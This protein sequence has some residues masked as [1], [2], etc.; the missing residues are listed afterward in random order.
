M[1]S[2]GQVLQRATAVLCFDDGHGRQQWSFHDTLKSIGE[3]FK[4]RQ[5]HSKKWL[6]LR[7]STDY[8]KGAKVCIQTALRS[9][10]LFIV[11]NTGEMSTFRKGEN[12]P[13]GIY[14]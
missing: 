13:R 14:S 10:A 3:W 5:G 6:D 7:P 11:N 9:Q 4:A 12:F 1:M 2:I 8:N